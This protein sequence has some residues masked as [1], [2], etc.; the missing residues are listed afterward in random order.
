M[1]ED[2]PSN[3]FVEILKGIGL[4]ILHH[5]LAVSVIGIVGLVIGILFG[6]NGVFQIWAMGAVGFFLLQLAYVI[7]LALRLK[8]QGKTGMMKGVIIGATITALLNGTCSFMVF[9]AVSFYL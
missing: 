2:R 7:P 6:E 9:R 1:T 4:L 8:R 3:E 5:I